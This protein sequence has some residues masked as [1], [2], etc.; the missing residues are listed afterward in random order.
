LGHHIEAYEEKKYEARRT[1]EN[2]G[3]KERKAPR[4]SG[5]GGAAGWHAGRAASRLGDIQGGLA[6]RCRVDGEARAGIQGGAGRC[7]GRRSRAA[8]G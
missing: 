7:P 8:P 1:D 4:L 2:I 6:R 3:E 5:T